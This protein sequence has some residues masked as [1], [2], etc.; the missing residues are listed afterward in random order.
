M[1]IKR[2]SIFIYTHQADPAVL[3]EVCAG[4]EE[5][6]VFY[7]TAEFPESSPGFHAG[8]RDR[9]L[10]HGSVPENARSGKGMQYRELSCAQPDPVQ[11]HRRKQRPRHQETAF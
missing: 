7:D 6:G 10:R 4:I 2:P 3:K 8:I 9:H 5:E 1:I 11:E